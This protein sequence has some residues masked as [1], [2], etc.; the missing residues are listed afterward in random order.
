MDKPKK[1][2]LARA[3]EKMKLMEKQDQVAKKLSEAPKAQTKGHHEETFAEM[4][5]AQQVYSELFN[6]A[7]E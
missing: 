1:G 6:K 2:L 3:E 7:P 5:T 4:Q